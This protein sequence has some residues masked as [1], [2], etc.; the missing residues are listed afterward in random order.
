VHLGRS[1][2]GVEPDVADELVLLDAHDPVK[3]GGTGK[4]VD[5]RARRVARIAP[6][7]SRRRA[8][9]GQRRQA[10][11]EVARSRST[12]R[13]ASSRTGRKGITKK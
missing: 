6:R 13:R 12:W 5:W 7:H 11:D 1:S 9:A 2:D 4:T 8:D 3:H 10:I